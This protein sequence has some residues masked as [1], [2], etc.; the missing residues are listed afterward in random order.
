MLG[1]FIVWEWQKQLS[2]SANKMP[3][4]AAGMATVVALGCLS[5]PIFIGQRYSPDTGADYVKNYGH[6]R[7][8]FGPALKELPSRKQG[9]W[10][11]A[12][13]HIRT[14]SNENDTMYVWGW[15]PGIYVQAQRLAPVP[16][17]FESDM[18]VKSPSLLQWE[19][20]AIVNQME[21]S[22][23]KFIVDSR[24]R[25]FP[26]DRPPLELWPIVPP[27]TFGNEKPRFLKNAPQEV[28]AFDAGWSN[29]LESQIEP[30]EAERY[31]AMKPFRDFVMNHYRIVK[32]YGNHILFE[33]LE[34]P[35]QQ[36]Q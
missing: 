19:I 10:V 35:R 2:L 9:A 12:G 13:E 1:G 26:N 33:Y 6:R 7:R 30:D 3:L 36:T 17:A 34:T 11:A 24:K 16:K 18:H 28:A 14:H 32:Q 21:N 23:P 22:P 4:L 31:E 25:H 29:F 8:G 20:N 15:M 27:N 5:I